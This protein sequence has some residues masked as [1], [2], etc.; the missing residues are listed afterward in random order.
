MEA[1][2]G[3]PGVRDDRLLDSALAAPDSAF[4]GTEF[5]PTVEAKAARLA[6]GLVANHPFVDGNKRVGILAMLVLLDLGG[7]TVEASDDELVAL[8]LGL[9]RRE[10]DSEGVLAWIGTHVER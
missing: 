9:A 8:G 6:F 10:I 7:I 4:E 1:T 3:A 5:Y 2:G